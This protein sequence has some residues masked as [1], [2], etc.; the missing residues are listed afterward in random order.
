MD[1]FGCD[2]LTLLAA[3]RNHHCQDVMII[4][5]LGYLADGASIYQCDQVRSL[6]DSPSPAI[7]GTREKVV[8]TVAPD[9]CLWFLHCSSTLGGIKKAQR[10][11]KSILFQSGYV[12]SCEGMDDDEVN[13]ICSFVEACLEFEKSN[14]A[15]K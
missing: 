10:S 5:R 9:L 12:R 2:G 8:G 7:Y 14:A 4:K 15:K 1:E 3:L 13:G 6:H 11:Y